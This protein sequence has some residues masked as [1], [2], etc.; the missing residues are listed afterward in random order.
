MEIIYRDSNFTLILKKTIFNPTSGPSGLRAD[1]Q[2]SNWLPPIELQTKTIKAHV[3]LEYSKTQK[4]PGDSVIEC[5]SALSE[6]ILSRE[7]DVSLKSR[8]LCVAFSHTRTGMVD[9]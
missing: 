9:A 1:I 4:R 6:I 8:T 3:R 5:N 7:F 2:F